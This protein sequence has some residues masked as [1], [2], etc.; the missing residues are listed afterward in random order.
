[1][2]SHYHFDKLIHIDLHFIIKEKRLAHFKHN[3]MLNFVN[4]Y[5]RVYNHIFDVVYYWLKVL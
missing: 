1:M 5:L 2:K 3:T 4:F